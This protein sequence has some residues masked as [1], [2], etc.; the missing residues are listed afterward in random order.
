[1]SSHLAIRGVRPV[2]AEHPS[3]RRTRRLGR[4]AAEWLLLAVVTTGVSSWTS[5]CNRSSSPA[6]QPPSQTTAPVASS[7][8]AG[9][10]GHADPATAAQSPRSDLPVDEQGFVTF[11]NESSLPA[12]TSAANFANGSSNVSPQAPAVPEPSSETGTGSELTLGSPEGN[13]V[14]LGA[15][16]APPVAAGAEATQAPA[17]DPPRK[18]TTAPGDP[19]FQLAAEARSAGRLPAEANVATHDE[20]HQLIA[21]DWPQPQAVLFITGQQQGYLEPCGCTG[22]ANQKGGLN[23]RD[24]LLQQ[25]RDRDWEVIP[26]DV[27]GFERRQGPQAMLKFQVTAGALKEMGYRAATL[28]LEDLRLPNGDLVAVTASS[29][30]DK[31]GQTNSPTHTPYISANSYVLLE[32]FMPKR[33]I[34]E[35]GGRKIGITA[36]L[37]DSWRKKLDPHS[38]V[39]SQDAAEAL[40]PVVAELQQA[41]CD[42]LVLLAHAS[43]EDSADLARR[44]P[45]FHL[46][47]TAGGFGEPTYMP[48]PID[49]SEAVMVQVGTKGMYAGILGLYPDAQQPV[50]YQRIA[51][52]S[53]FE[54]SPRMLARFADYQRQLRDMGFEKLGLSPATHPTGRQ[55]VGSQACSDCHSRAFEK[56]QETGH[57]HA[58]E[59]LVSP[60]ERS[61]IQRHFDPE[62]LSCHVTGWNPQ[63]YYPYATGYESLERTPLLTGNGCENCHGPGSEHVKAENGDI[64][65]DAARLKELQEQM[66]LPLAEARERCLECH[67]LDNSPE[68]Q[69]DGAFDEYWK[70]I[71]HPWR[72]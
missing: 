10:S 62:C 30:V 68:F 66:R 7:S 44:V 8:G 43:L 3:P 64:Q 20:K 55:F 9:G 52:S 58:T 59:S 37:G 67:D 24:T 41:G 50:R 14:S 34:I 69:L 61:Q 48:E 35:A 4:P 49:G 27:G 16:Q 19:A 15:P 57:Y 26:V 40:Q 12:N 18:G 22:L 38:E 56:W 33:R 72:D 23:R 54:D 25:L 2:Q 47:V 63:K 39:E 13:A 21:V 6:P 31:P 65:V 11:G 71:A 28:G 5:G 70:K 32:E 51:L 46:V 45:G 17:F 60:G 53:Q 36:A 29:E 42:F 1:M